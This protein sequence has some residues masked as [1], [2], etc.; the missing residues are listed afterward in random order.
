[1]SH[2][3]TEYYLT[4]RKVKN[5][6]QF[7]ELSEELKKYDLLYYAFDS[8]TYTEK[9]GEAFFCPF[10][11]VTWFNHAADMIMISEKFPKMYFELEGIGEEYGD[12]WK[13]YY[14]D[15]ECEVCRGEVVFE[16]PKKVQWTELIPF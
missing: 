7:D 4:V 12:F 14:H 6:Q 10:E 9:N 16:Q 11:G 5:S 2:Y 13:E 1:M 3:H 15:G 8:G